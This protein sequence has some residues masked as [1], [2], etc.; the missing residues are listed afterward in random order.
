VVVVVVV[1]A[2]GEWSMGNGESSI[3]TLSH[4]PSCAASINPPIGAPNDAVVPC[5]SS[6]HHKTK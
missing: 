1:A 3:H 2:A 4:E 6:K 5:R